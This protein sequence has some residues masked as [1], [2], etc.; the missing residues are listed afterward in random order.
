MHTCLLHISTVHAEPD[1]SHRVLK[2]VPRGFQ[3]GVDIYY[4]DA[5][6][7]SAR[8]HVDVEF[9]WTA[10]LLRREAP[11]Y[12]QATLS[13]GAPDFL[14]NRYHSN[15][16]TRFLVH[17]SANDRKGDCCRITLRTRFGGS[18]IKLPTRFIAV[19]QNN[20]C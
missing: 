18:H 6:A 8:F 19:T 4:I 14:N 13:S 3:T 1:T 16:A 5:F 17:F 10:T 15:T 2:H 7:R 20:S 9:A 12:P 11:H